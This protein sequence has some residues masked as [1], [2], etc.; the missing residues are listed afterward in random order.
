MKLP[1]YVQWCMEALEAA[2]YS[3]YAVGGCVR[4][5]LLGL[6]PHDFDLCTSALPEQT[7]Q[8]FADQGLVL[9]GLKHGT[10]GVIFPEGVVEITTYRTEGGYTDSRH[11]DWVRFVDRIEDDLARRDFTINAMAWS[12]TRGLQDPFHGAEDLEHG[13]LRTVGV[14]QDRF[15]EDALRILRG[16]RFAARFHL[17]PEAQTYAAMVQLTPLMDGLARERVY[18]ELCKLLTVASA[19]DL[20]RY[21]PLI[22]R[23][24]PEL[25]VAVGFEQHSRYHAFDLYTHI[26][27][28][29]AA[30]PEELT[31]KWAALLH[32]V[33]K[34]MT[35]TLDEQQQGHFYGHA[36]EG[37]KLA[38][39]ILH[40]LKAPTVLR[41]QVVELVEQHMTPL[42]PQRKALRR[43]MSRLGTAQVWNLLELQ[44]SDMGGKGT[45]T[46]DVEQK[47]RFLQLRD[48]LDQLLEEDSCLTL[49]DLAVNGRDLMQLGIPAGKA[50]GSCLQSLLDAVLDEAL[51]NEKDPLLRAA[52]DYCDAEVSNIQG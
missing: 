48:M 34:P 24:I 47:D 44:Q 8:V 38:D 11:P 13:I 43:R 45:G 21:E 33:G 1:S 6:T 20:I 46:F 27:H 40:R 29:T 10:V 41:E 23:V 22:T 52:K 15:Q 32:D 31:L 35:F 39:Q 12:P 25:K 4:D 50:L 51:P 16:A 5:W 9:A 2:G 26:A 28:V 18:S 36:Q 37:A 42:L 3:A 19:E 7:Q 49:R 30:V 14:A 17:Q